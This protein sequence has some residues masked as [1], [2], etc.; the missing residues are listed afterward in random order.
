MFTSNRMKKEIINFQWRKLISWLHTRRCRV[1]QINNSA[2]FKSRRIE[3]TKWLDRLGRHGEIVQSSDSFWQ[4]N[5]SNSKWNQESYRRGWC[6]CKDRRHEECN[7]AFV[8]WRNLTPS[9]YHRCLLHPSFWRPHYSDAHASYLEIT[10]KTDAKG[11]L[12]KTPHN[13]LLVKHQMLLPIEVLNGW[14]ADL[15]LMWQQL[16]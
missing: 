14:I 7:H 16:W 13:S 4:R 12:W 5:P 10:D 9:V 15:A 6:S 11:S 1:L 3:I 8:E 2:N